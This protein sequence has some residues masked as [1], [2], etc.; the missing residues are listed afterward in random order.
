MS[1]AS[2]FMAVLANLLTHCVVEG[3]SLSGK[4]QVKKNN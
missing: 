4:L 1:A 2:K 3:N